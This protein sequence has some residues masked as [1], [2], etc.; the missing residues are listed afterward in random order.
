MADYRVGIYVIMDAKGGD[1]RDASYAAAAALLRLGEVHSPFKAHDGAAFP[2][3]NATGVAE[4][5]SSGKLTLAPS[6]AVRSGNRSEADDRILR[7]PAP[8]PVLE[9]SARWLAEHADPGDPGIEQEGGL[10]ISNLVYSSQAAYFA[11]A[12]AK[13]RGADPAEADAA[14]ELIEHACLMRRHER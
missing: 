12:S 10:D 14:Y 13:T 2:I 1:Y 6:Y 4:A 5:L 3:V 9:A 11:A 8:L 7:S